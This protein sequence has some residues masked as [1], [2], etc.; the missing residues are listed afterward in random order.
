MTDLEVL[1]NSIKNS[2]SDYFLKDLDGNNIVWIKNNVDYSYIKEKIEA[3][4]SIL[5]NNIGNSVETYVLNRNLKAGVPLDLNAEETLA[6]NRTG[7][8]E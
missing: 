2:L 5:S 4:I 1:K 8:L 6:S 7:D 3:K